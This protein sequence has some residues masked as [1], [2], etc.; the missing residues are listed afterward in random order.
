MLDVIKPLLDSELINEEAK[1]EIQEAWEAKL[2]ETRKSIGAELREEFAHRYEHDK[3][4]MVEAID[5]MVT[6][7]L[8]TEIE[9]VKS[10]KSQLEEDRVKFN[11]KMK[12]SA[13]KFDSFLVKKLAEEITDL[14]E[15]RKQQ[16]V[17][18]EKMEQFVV[19][20][21]AREITEFA[22]DKKDVIETKVRLVAE[23]R[24][25]LEALK[26]KFISESASKMTTAV[27][28]HLKAE[29]SQLHE[30][31]KV[32][33][34][35]SFGR[36]IFEAFA[37]EF[38]GTHLNENEE[39]RKLKAT[40]EGKD[41]QLH[42][43]TAKLDE[44]NKLVETKDKEVNMIKDKNVREAKLTELLSPLNTEKEEVMRNLL[45]SVQTTRLENAFEKY[46]PAVLSEDVVKSKKTKL[47]ESVKEVTGDKA[48]QKKAEEDN[49]NVIDLRRLAGL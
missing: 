7:S 1:E 25:K 45:E 47:T 38:V 16:K 15:D 33:R 29:L 10:E 2:A 28:K 42:E 6:E 23:A 17:T 18:M 20:A 41:Q 27:A 8:T 21:L 30:D 46:L 11:A 13:Q 14:R 39:I 24:E 31:I 48:S 49:T 12:E 36:K 26:E 32:A 37:S 34:E 3:Q 35:N 5:R 40:I 19:K 44:T 9:A 43:T 4:N 22:E